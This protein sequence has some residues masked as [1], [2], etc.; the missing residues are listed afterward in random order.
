MA[1]CGARLRGP[2]VFIFSSEARV[3]SVRGDR[4]THLPA[5]DS[6]TD[7]KVFT[8]ASLPYGQLKPETPSYQRPVTSLGKQQKLARA[9][10]G[11]WTS[12]RGLLAA[13]AQAALVETGYS[14]SQ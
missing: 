13:S 6:C 8:R 1:W 9:A 14:S 2:L 7:L 3:A 12:E 5:Y 4:G 11:V 10:R